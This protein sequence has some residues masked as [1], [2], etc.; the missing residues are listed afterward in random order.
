[1]GIY[2]IVGTNGMQMKVN[3]HMGCFNIGDETPYEDGL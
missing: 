1:M 3:P 2:D